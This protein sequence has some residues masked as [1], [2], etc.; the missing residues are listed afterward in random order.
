MDVTTSCTFGWES[1]TCPFHSGSVVQLACQ[2]YR[3]R[4]SLIH[5]T[6]TPSTSVAFLCSTYQLDLI[7]MGD[8]KPWSLF[9]IWL[10]H[11]PYVCLLKK[12]SCTKIR[13]FYRQI[14]GIFL[15]WRES[16]LL[17]ARRSKNPFSRQILVE[18]I[19][20]VCIHNYILVELFSKLN[21][22]YHV[23]KPLSSARN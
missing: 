23:F 6:W 19:L 3:L 12:Q 13:S 7:E 21:R 2:V 15:P 14:Y 20:Q 16:M 4:P 8:R 18:E 11:P 10:I 9:P 1:K 17:S 5:W 22:Y